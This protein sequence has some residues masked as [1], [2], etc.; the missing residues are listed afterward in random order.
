MNGDTAHREKHFEAYVVEK[1]KAQGWK[2][3]DSKHYDTERALYPDDLVAWLEA[4]QPTKW[5]TIS[6]PASIGAQRSVL[7]GCGDAK[8]AQCE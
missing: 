3:G 5:V 6:P 1:L 4:T 8:D 2:V 7:A